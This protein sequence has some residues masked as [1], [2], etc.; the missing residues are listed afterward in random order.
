MLMPSW[1]QRLILFNNLPIFINFIKKIIINLIHLIFTI[2]S[3]YHFH[4]NYFFANF[5][6]IFTSFSLYLVTFVLYFHYI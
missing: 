4:I 6:I 2:F 3:D 1:I 5:I